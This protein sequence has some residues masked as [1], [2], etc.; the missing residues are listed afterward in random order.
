MLF[1]SIAFALVGIEL[2]F[3]A[4]TL[5]RGVWKATQI[6]V[7]HIAFARVGTNS[8]SEAPSVIAQF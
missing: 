1:S 5:K 8:L 3:K 4:H 6:L 7:E 2:R